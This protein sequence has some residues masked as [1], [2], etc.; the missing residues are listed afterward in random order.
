LSLQGPLA[1]TELHLKFKPGVGGRLEVRL[2]QGASLTRLAVGRHEAE[3]VELSKANPVRNDRLHRHLEPA[4][5]EPGGPLEV[6][7]PPG[8]VVLA[9]FQELTAQQEYR[10]PLAGLAKLDRLELQATVG[11][12]RLSWESCGVKHAGDWCVPGPPDHA[13]LRCADMALLRLK[14]SGPLRAQALG[15][16]LILVDSSARRAGRYALSGADPG[17][18]DDRHPGCQAPSGLL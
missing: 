18:P 12:E 4:H 8:D 16:L 6:R 2:P 14:P 15:N 17:R 7:I 13:E 11:G 1:L 10:L 5:Q 9:Y 3:I